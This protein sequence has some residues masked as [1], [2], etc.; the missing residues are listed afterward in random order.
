MARGLSS[1]W[2]PPLGTTT[3]LVPATYGARSGT[4][5][6]RSAFPLLQW[7]KQDGLNRRNVR[8]GEKSMERR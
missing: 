3:M 5:M 4:T 6:A 2:Y 1:G 7:M 8:H